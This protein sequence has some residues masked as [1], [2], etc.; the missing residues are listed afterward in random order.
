MSRDGRICPRYEVGPCHCLHAPRTSQT[1][2]HHNAINTTLTSLSNP[3][4]VFQS[5]SFNRS[6]PQHKMNPSSPHS[7]SVPPPKRTVITMRSRQVFSVQIGHPQHD[8]ELINTTCSP[9][10]PADDDAECDACP[11]CNDTCSISSC[12]PCLEKMKRPL[13]M[14][15][16]EPQGW[17]MGALASVCPAKNDPQL[18]TYSMCQLRRHNTVESAWILV[19]KDIYDATPY[20]KSHPG[21]TAIILKKAGGARDCTEDLN[22][23][24]T[25]AQKEWRRY[26][27]G[28]LCRCPRS[29]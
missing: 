17:L 23:H 22:F 19:G 7:S 28:T 11:C 21:G 2:S 25:R 8:K 24:S 16:H 14:G 20:I 6:W 29:S 27:V 15:C 26:K 5:K 18:A 10:N 9:C 1:S 12:I 13:N 3:P 4:K